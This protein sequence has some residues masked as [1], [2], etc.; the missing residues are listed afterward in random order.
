MPKYRRLTT[1][2]LHNLESDFIDYLVVNTITGDDWV[3]LKDTN[4]DKAGKIIELF[5][6]VVF[7]K[8][9]RQTHYLDHVSDSMI[10]SFHYQPSQAVMICAKANNPEIII[11]EL[12]GNKKGNDNQT[13]ND[14]DI[15]IW[16]TTKIYTQQRELEIY[17]MISN[18][19]VVSDGQLYKRLAL[20]M[21]E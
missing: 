8:V 12:F 10:T 6:D 17:Q 15:E 1:E 13:D 5:S 21:V 19:A 4:P 18:G 20:S 9:M 2:E 14:L 7:E 3:K 11:T 16:T